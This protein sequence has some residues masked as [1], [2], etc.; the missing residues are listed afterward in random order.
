MTMDNK[1]KT[2]AKPTQ[3]KPVVIDPKKVI[4]SKPIYIKENQQ[5][6]SK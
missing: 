5:Y 1:K 4:I 2:V 3:S 6:P